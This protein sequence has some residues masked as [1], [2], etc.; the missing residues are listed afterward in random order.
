M[1]RLRIAVVHQEVT[2]DSPPDELD[3]LAQ[4]DTVCSTLR[5]LGCE[6]RAMP[7]SLDLAL[8]TTHLKA[9]R[10]NLVFNLVES[11]EGQCRLLALFPAVLDSMGMPYTGSKTETLLATT[12]KVWAKRCLQ[13]AGILTPAWIGPYPSDLSSLQREGIREE[14]T[15]EGSWIIKSL[16]EHASF[17]LDDDDL[18]TGEDERH[19]YQV[20]RER[21][22]LLGGACFA[23]AFIPG[24]EFNLSLLAGPSGPQVMVP[25]EIMFEGY[26]PDRLRIVGYRAKWDTSSF[27]YHHTPRRFEFLEEDYSLLTEMEETARRCWHLLNIRGYARVDFRVDEQNRPW[28]LEINANPCLSPDAGYAAALA[29][30]GISFRKA[31]ERIVEETSEELLL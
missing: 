23:E 1:N 25:A 2:H 14:D 16:W 6:P 29:E 8:I 13:T 7:C 31:I 22:A 20:L 27:E 17:G 21:S 11:L 26:E 18:I 12:H 4:V 30:S 28:V 24:R 10:P 5:E 3:I 9:W 15:E 19:I